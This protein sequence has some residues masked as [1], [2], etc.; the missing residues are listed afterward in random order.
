MR[1]RAVSPPRRSA[2]AT[3]V[4]DESFFL[5]IWVRY[6]SQFFG[7][8]DMYVLDHDTR[9]GST[10]RD[11]IVRIPVSHDSVDHVW[12]RDALQ[13]LQH[14]LLQRYDSVI[15]VDADEI[16][17]PD[18]RIGTLGD[19]LDR[20][21]ADFVN[22][23][24]MEIVHE[25]AE[26]GPYDPSRPIL[27][28][29][30]YWKRNAWY[31][32]PALAREPMHWIPGFHSRT[33]AQSN[34]DENLYLVHLHRVDYDAC[35]LRHERRRQL[36]WNQHDFDK[37]WALYNRIVDEEEFERWFYLDMVT[38]GTP[39]FELERIPEHWRSAF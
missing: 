17:V 34:P 4:H 38:A 5:P 28:Q 7:P 2:I 9:D 29:R 18:P 33:D 16:V 31:D 13:D 10:A 3:I 19:Y 6:Y 14:E 20:F 27:D 39:R 23:H 37:G 36:A 32:K 26:E 1:R 15:V 21:S 11:D 22:C 25:K 12:M 24:G 8:G 30:H 35:L